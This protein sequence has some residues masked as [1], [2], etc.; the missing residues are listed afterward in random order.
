MV[1]TA[2]SNTGPIHRRAHRQRGVML[3]EL[4]VAAFFFALSIALVAQLISTV[5]HLRRDADR[6]ELATQEAANAMERITSWPFERITQESADKLELSPIAR[7]A[8]PGAQLA[9]RVTDT[10]APSAMKRIAIV[11]RWRG[12]P[13]GNE[14]PVRLTAWVGPRGRAKP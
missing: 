9:A 10:P 1:L 14:A 11:L 2:R 12:G 5:L 3:I 8:L 13:A 7:Q 4:T 6:R